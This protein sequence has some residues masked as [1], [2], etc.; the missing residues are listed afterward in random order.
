MTRRLALALLAA[1]PLATPA[2]AAEKPAAAAFATGK[3]TIAGEAFAP[4]EVLDAR[5]LPDVNGKVGI[6]L[7]LTPAAAKRLE[8]I[9]ASLIGKPML[10]ALDGRTL[11]AELIR[12]PVADGVIEIPGRWNLGDGEALARR[13][14]GRDPLPDDLA[15]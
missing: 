12:K 5:A 15:E 14:S 1:L 9:T 3:L 13:V 11:A 10:V 7:T 8:A 4:A 2:C 6:M